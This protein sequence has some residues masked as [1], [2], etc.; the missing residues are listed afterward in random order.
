M[1][2]ELANVPSIKQNKSPSLP[3]ENDFSTHSRSFYR[4]GITFP[5]SVNIESCR[6][7]DCH[8]V[9]YIIDIM[10]IGPRE[11]EASAGYPRKIV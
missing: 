1:V 11:Q 6:N 7:L 10:L 3:C 2:I 8:E 9:L 5:L 4:A